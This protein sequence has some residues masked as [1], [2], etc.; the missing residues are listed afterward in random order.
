M[1]SVENFFTF[2][3]NKLNSMC[4]TMILHVYIYTVLSVRLFM[5]IRPQKKS[6][7]CGFV[8]KYPTFSKRK[9]SSGSVNILQNMF[10][11]I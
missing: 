8:F 5:H 2:I 1:N 10:N 9:W 3:Y 6:M 7:V 11:T 4:R